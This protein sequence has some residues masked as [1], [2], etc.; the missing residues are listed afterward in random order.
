MDTGCVQQDQRTP[1]LSVKA[2][3]NV[4]LSA[5]LRTVSSYNRLLCRGGGGFVCYV[6]HYSKQLLYRGSHGEDFE[7]YSDRGD[8]ARDNNHLCSNST[9]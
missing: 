1:I 8:T 6:L 3:G 4:R 2:E 9:L 7:D 5:C